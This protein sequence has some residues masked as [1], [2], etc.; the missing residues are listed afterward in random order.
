MNNIELEY[1]SEIEFSQFDQ[2]EKKFNQ[3]AKL[4]SHAK[5]LSF[6]AFGDG[7]DIRVR[8]TNGKSEVVVKKGDWHAENRIEISQDIENDQFVGFVKIFSAMIKNCNIGERENFV[9]ENNDGV[10]ITLVKS[11]RLAYVE[12][13]LISRD[14][15]IETNKKIIL[16]L[17]KSLNL[18]ILDKKGF[19]DLC[20]RLKV[21]DDW[22]FNLEEDK[23]SKLE[24]L[25]S[26]YSKL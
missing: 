6:M 15:N 12:F 9:F 26:E 4:K 13:E 10:T 25:L 11:K 1:R 22:K 7:I 5:R 14:E 21:N 24:G 3:I 19:D 20:D 17:M 2:F 16:D 23:V 8:I 18:E